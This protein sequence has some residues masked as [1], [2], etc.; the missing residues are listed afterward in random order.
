MMSPDIQL[1]PELGPLDE[2]ERLLM[3]A[4]RLLDAEKV[5]LA[6][7]YAATAIDAIARHRDGQDSN[8]H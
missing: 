3:E 1:K 5:H 4:L 7:A 8:L 6:A 2:A